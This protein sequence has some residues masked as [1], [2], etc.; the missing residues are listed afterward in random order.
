MLCMSAA[1][2]S[3]GWTAIAALTCLEAVLKL[4][5]VQRT[6]C[7]VLTETLAGHPLYL[8]QTL[9]DLTAHFLMVR[10]VA[11]S[12]YASRPPGKLGMQGRLLMHTYCHEHAATDNAAAYTCK[13][14]AIC[15]HCIDGGICSDS[16]PCF[17]WCMTMSRVCQPTPLRVMPTSC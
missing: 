10:D 5:C 8:T 11:A 12:S 14:I 6:R 17:R 7:L 13:T 4:A 3:L 1:Q 16:Q 2:V 9:Q 15:Q